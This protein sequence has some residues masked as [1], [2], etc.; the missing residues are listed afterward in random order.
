MYQNIFV[1]KKEAPV[2]HLW[3]D[4]KGYVSFA[5]PRY[6]YQKSPNGKFKS[7]YGD[8]LEKIFAFDERDT[9]LFESDIQ[10]S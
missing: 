2:V 4:T 10:R 5:F 8:N 7:L 3:D 9:D 1:D 6:A